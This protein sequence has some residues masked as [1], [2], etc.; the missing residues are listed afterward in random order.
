MVYGSVY[1]S[2]AEGTMIPA[3][4]APDGAFVAVNEA[5]ELDQAMF[6]AFIERDFNELLSRNNPAIAESYDVLNESFLGDVWDKILTILKKLKDKVVSIMKAAAIRIGA[7]FTRDNAELV[8]KYMK[9]FDAA[10]AKGVDLEIKD[11]IDP[12]NAFAVAGTVEDLQISAVFN[13]VC[14]MS[15]KEEVDAYMEDVEAE[16]CKNLVDGKCTSIKDIKSFVNDISG[17][18]KKVDPNIVKTFLTNSKAAIDV[19]DSCKNTFLKELKEDEIAANKMK[20]NAKKM[21]DGEDKDNALAVANAAQ[22]VVTMTQKVVNTSC[23]AVI[24]LIKKVIKSNRKAFITIATRGTKNGEKASKEVDSG[25]TKE[26]TEATDE[27]YLLQAELDNQDYVVESAFD[28][29]IPES[30]LVA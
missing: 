30:E 25:K 3:Y 18:T 28:E 12:K 21:D 27:A 19:V 17:E 16:L 29:Y 6:D 13:K 23:S 20:A 14:A 10:V 24:S 8:R 9:Q 1:G 15:T 7:F 2:M 26:G 4:A 5:I 22:K 11:Y